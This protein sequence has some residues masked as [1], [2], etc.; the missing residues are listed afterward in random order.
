MV[1]A[2]KSLELVFFVEAKI[3]N[4]NRT[5]K[6]MYLCIVSVPHIIWSNTVGSFG[7]CLQYFAN[8]KESVKEFM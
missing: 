6:V 8:P 4:L 5:L 1:C 7:I 2:L 3:L